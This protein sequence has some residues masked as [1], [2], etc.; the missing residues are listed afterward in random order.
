MTQPPEPPSGPS[1]GAPYGPGYGPQYGVP[2]VKPTNGKATA[3]LAT[4]ITTLVLSWC[5]GFGLLGV[6]AIVLGVKARNEISASGGAQQGDGL[7]LGGIITG[8]IAVVLGLLIL[9]LIIIAVI[10]GARF[11]TGG[12]YG[13]RF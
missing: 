7:A 6:V 3:S 5:C 2:V 13:T 11:D 4:G 8:A 1:Y 10:A 9:V 12:G